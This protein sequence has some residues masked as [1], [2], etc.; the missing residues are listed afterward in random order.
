MET[1]SGM[2][3]SSPRGPS[4]NARLPDTILVLSAAFSA[5]AW[6]RAIGLA[7]GSSEVTGICETKSGMTLAIRSAGSSDHALVTAVSF[8]AIHT[9]GKLGS[10]GDVV[11]KGKRRT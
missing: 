6:T 8:F 11:E 4:G 9:S 7:L 10:V 5:M 2:R 3:V 1:R